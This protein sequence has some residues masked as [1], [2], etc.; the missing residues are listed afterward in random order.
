MDGDD[1]KV[2]EGSELVVARMA[3][4][5]NESFY[6]VDDRKKTSTQVTDL[7]KSKG[8]DLDHNRF[9]IL[10]GEVEQ[11]S[12]MPPVSPNSLAAPDRLTLSFVASGH[13][14]IY[15]SRHAAIETCKASAIA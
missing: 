11:I 5:E 7:L 13:T 3:T 1:Y 6:Y 8:I 12:L 10:Q 15:D 4:K 14:K 2:I 9:L